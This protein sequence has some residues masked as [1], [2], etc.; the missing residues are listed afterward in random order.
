MRIFAGLALLGMLCCNIIFGQAVS[1]I[2]GI[3]KD[4]TGA[5]VPDVQVTATQ[6][7]TGVKRMAMTDSAGYY[8]LPNLP[9]GP[10]RL[11]AMKV[12]FQT[13]VQTGIV[14][15]VGTAPEIPHHA[16]RRPGDAGRPG[17]SQRQSGGNAN[18]WCRR[19][20]WR[21]SAFVDLPLNGRDPTQLITLSGRGRAREPD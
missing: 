19:M 9:L 7:D 15:Q 1:Q 5:V 3:V 12:G 14:L 17:G 2:S 4:S 18:R 20:W 6:T 16:S 10:Y 21:P 13:Y 11:E 8:V